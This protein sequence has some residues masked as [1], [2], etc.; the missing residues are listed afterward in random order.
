MINNKSLL[1]I[2]INLLLLVLIYFSYCYFS[3]IAYFYSD[4]HTFNIY[5]ILVLIKNY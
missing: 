1:Y 3:E 2:L 4:N 5:T